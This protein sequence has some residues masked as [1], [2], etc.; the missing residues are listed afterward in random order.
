MSKHFKCFGESVSH[1][2]HI[3]LFNNVGAKVDESMQ[4]AL[5]NFLYF[6]VLSI[7]GVGVS[8]EHPPVQMVFRLREI[9]KVLIPS[10]NGQGLVSKIP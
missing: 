1:V 10:V 4:I 5:T 6:L 9:L 8:I 7:S 3:G 2:D